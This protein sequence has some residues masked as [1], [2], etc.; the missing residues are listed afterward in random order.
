MSAIKTD[1]L[2]NLC[3]EYL[4]GTVSDFEKLRMKKDVKS[5]QGNARVDVLDN[6]STQDIVRYLLTLQAVVK[7]FNKSKFRIL[8]GMAQSAGVDKVLLSF[9]FCGFF[10]GQVDINADLEAQI[11][12]I[13]RHIQKVDAYLN[14]SLSSILSF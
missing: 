4:E 6:C 14:P 13:N 9:S 2:R 5:R 12:K 10:Q 3:D 11:E 1:K 7:Q 8:R